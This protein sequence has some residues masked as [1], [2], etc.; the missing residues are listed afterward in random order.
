MSRVA[1]VPED[2]LMEV[3]SRELEEAGF[4]KIVRDAEDCAFA[5]AMEMSNHYMRNLSSS[6]EE[7]DYCATDILAGYL[8]QAAQ[9]IA[10]MTDALVNGSHDLITVYRMM[11]VADISLKKYVSTLR[12]FNMQLE[13]RAA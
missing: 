6:L 7:S 13:S 5:I 12:A 1:V 10:A 8:D 9:D 11:E 2:K 4:K 3:L